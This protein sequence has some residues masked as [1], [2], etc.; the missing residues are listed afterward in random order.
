[1]NVKPFPSAPDHLLRDVTG[2]ERRRYH[3]DGVVRLE[4]MIPEAWID[5]L[6]DTVDAP[7]INVPDSSQNHTPTGQP[8]FFTQAFSRF[9]NP[10]L[11]AWALDGPTRH[12][13]AQFH[14]QARTLR[15][16]YDQVFAQEPGSASAIRYLKGSHRGPSALAARGSEFRCRRQNHAEVAAVLRLRRWRLWSLMLSLVERQ[17]ATTDYLNVLREQR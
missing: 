6:R 14:P 7:M 15:F 2:D 17:R 4:Q 16:F 3:R 11:N 9:V 5:R 1:M 10:T 8:R 12:I 13:A